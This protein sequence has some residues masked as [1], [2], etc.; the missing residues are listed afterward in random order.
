M[1]DLLKKCH[2]GKAP[3]V[4]V[5]PEGRLTFVAV[6]AKYFDKTK[7][8]DKGQFCVTLVVPPGAD[9]D[10][11]KGIIKDAAVEKFGSKMP[12][13]MKTPLRDA[14]EVDKEGY[15]KGWTMIRANTYTAPPGVV[16]A[17]GVNV[18][19][20]R[21]GESVEEQKARIEAEAYSGRWA[22]ATVTAKGYDT[23]GNKGVKLYLNNVQLLKHDTKLSTARTSAEDDFEPVSGVE[24]SASVDADSIFG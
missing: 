20:L 19:A 9:L 11:L 2:A 16:D 3:G 1:S 21:P 7:P 4:V 5:T 17:K 6:A 22:R 10:M 14:G 12:G 23:N 18:S 8:E 15:E 24:G 13:G